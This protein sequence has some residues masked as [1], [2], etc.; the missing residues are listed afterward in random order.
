[1]LYQLLVIFSMVILLDLMSGAATLAGEKPKPPVAKKKPK[2]D[3][4]HGDVRVDNY[5]W[6]REKDNP[7]VI[8]YL[9][10]ENT[11][12][13]AMTADIKDLSE[14]IYKEMRG[15]IK[16]ADLSVPYKDGDYF[17]YTRYEEGKQYP[18]YCRKKGSLDGIEEVTLDLNKL[19]EGK[20]FIALGDYSVSDNGEWLAYTLDLTGFRQYTLYVKNLRTGDVMKDVR[21]RVTGAEWA[22]DNKTLFYTTE[23]KI[24]K[25]SNQLFRMTVGGTKDELLYEEKD[26]LFGTYISRSR[27]K[28]Y[29]FSISAS[30]ETSEQRFLSS[31]TP[32]G[33]FK[34]ILPRE[35]KHEYFAEHHDGLFYTRTNK[36]AKNFRIVT[37]PVN[38]PTAW[39]DFIA[40]NAAVKLEGMVMFKEFIV[41]SQR[42]NGLP[43]LR[44]VEFNTK[45]EHLVEVPEPV[46]TINAA[47]TP[48][49]ETNTLRF[50][51]QSLVTPNS[52]YDY[53]MSTKERKLMK[54]QEVVGGYDAAQYASERVFATAADGKKIPIAI[55]YKKGFK[56]DGNAPLLLYA[57][58]SYGFSLPVTF[59]SA[60]L[61][62][63][64]RG[65]VYAQASIRGGGD[66]G[67]E[68]HD[69]G[70]MM[71]K[72]N[73][74]TDFIACADYL[75]KEK[76]SS[77]KRM[78]IEGGSAGGLLIGAVLN[79]RPDVCKVA[80]LAVP[81]V[82]VINTMLDETLPL[83]V[84][85]FI[86]WGN[87]KI[88]EQYDYMKTYCPYTNL[89]AKN[90]PSIL[91]T[92][93]LNDSQV[94]YWE[95]AKY[96]AKL[97]DLKTD[98]NPLLLKTNMDAGHGGSSGRFDRLKEIAFE[99]A[100]MMRELGVVPSQTP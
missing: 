7:E 29:L 85:E 76:Y 68:W 14:K 12:T 88:K 53:N 62:L 58:G 72:M 6:L 42:Q 81:F 82:D 79:L 32:N 25:R 69:D 56:R 70:K 65:V 15:R 38:A 28:K 91:V 10:A 37:A 31:D 44:V 24:T 96:V 50:T 80:H 73:T 17:Y 22:A 61:S 48:E 55:V 11:Y 34:V 75:V 40:H 51:Y 100:F 94:M 83:T 43:E 52:V 99:Y 78:A 18:I 54:Q 93:S 47:A 59:S 67:E 30:S 97:R 45:A 86:E 64:D 95:P 89:A 60:R 84:G 20:K 49:Y 35:N 16:E 3:K 36:D 27:D 63:L 9:N 74:F 19:G 2:T 46:Y 21:E 1:M 39:T 41:I 8:A 71:K 87:P 77:H 23:D 57:Y 13:D 26:E 33:T 5:Y 90:Y 98:K 66:M 4:L 92:T